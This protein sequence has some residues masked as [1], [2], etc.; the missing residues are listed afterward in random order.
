MLTGLLSVLQENS[1]LHTLH[2][3]QNAMSSEVMDAVIEML[4]IN[5][6]LRDIS[7]AGNSK[8]TSE[9][10]AKFASMANKY[11]KIQT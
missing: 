6:T 5:T 11:R 3:T 1:T 4:N 10:R 2:I 9:Y 8:M 7:L